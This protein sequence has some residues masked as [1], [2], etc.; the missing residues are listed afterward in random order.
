MGGFYE[1]P[2]NHSRN[3][4][5]PLLELLS[6]PPTRFSSHNFDHLVYQDSNDDPYCSYSNISALYSDNST[7]FSKDFKNAVCAIPIPTYQQ[8]AQRLKQY[9]RGVGHAHTNKGLPE[10]LF[11]FQEATPR[12][13][14][15]ETRTKLAVRSHAEQP[16]KLS[17][18]TRHS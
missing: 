8:A 12:S 3:S 1:S 16:Q 13:Q 9:K 17:P 6:Y 11:E 14:V 5:K 7:Y 2:F 10:T 4:H 18:L 15:T